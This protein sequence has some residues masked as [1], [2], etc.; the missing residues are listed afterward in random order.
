MDND[1]IN[2]AVSE[3]ATVTMPGV[4]TML[5]QLSSGKWLVRFLVPDPAMPGSGTYREGVGDTLIE[6]LAAAGG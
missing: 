4:N 2:R 3:L 5:M 1:I 6:A